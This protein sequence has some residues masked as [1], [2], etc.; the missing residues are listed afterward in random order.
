MTGARVTA[1]LLDPDSQLDAAVSFGATSASTPFSLTVG[2]SRRFGP[3]VT[4]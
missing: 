4:P 3:R 2:Y 1:L